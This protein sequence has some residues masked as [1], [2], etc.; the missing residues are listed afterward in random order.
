MP[1]RLPLGA[2]FV[3]CVVARVDAA[4]AAELFRASL[5]PE[6]VPARPAPAARRARPSAPSAPRPA[7]RL[8]L[9]PPPLSGGAPLRLVAA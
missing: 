6:T 4:D 9:A 8:R 1:R 5:A 7:G 3:A 2:V